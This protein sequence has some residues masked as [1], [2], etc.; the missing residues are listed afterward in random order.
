MLLGLAGQFWTL[1]VW[2]YDASA[3]PHSPAPESGR[4]FELNFHGVSVYQTA[5]EHITYW[6]ID[7]GSSALFIVGFAL[8]V[9]HVWKSEGLRKFLRM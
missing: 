7:D 8:G 5:R 9:V 2:N 3:L 1:A 4:V 6:S